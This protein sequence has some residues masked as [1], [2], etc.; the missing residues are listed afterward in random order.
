MKISWQEGSSG[1]QGGG[2]SLEGG[3]RPPLLPSLAALLLEV[4][5]VQQLRHVHVAQQPA[6]EDVEMRAS[7]VRKPAAAAG[8][9]T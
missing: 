4:A 5:G 7:T 3:G 8:L 2:T 1:L 6:S 9:P